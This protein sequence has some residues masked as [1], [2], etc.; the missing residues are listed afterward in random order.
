MVSGLNA[1][2]NQESLVGSYPLS[3]NETNLESLPASYVIYKLEIKDLITKMKT[4][5]ANFAVST[6]FHKSV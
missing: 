2:T 4:I 5:Q 1:Y 3:I 6:E